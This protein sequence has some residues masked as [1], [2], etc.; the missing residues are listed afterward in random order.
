MSIPDKARDVQIDGCL[1]RLLGDHADCYLTDAVGNKVPGSVLGFAEAVP[2]T[3][4]SA[5]LDLL[6]D[7]L[8]DHG[9]AIGDGPSGPRIV[10][11]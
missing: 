3:A 6:V 8:R 5:L 7:E 2:I 4:Y 10:K 9:L 1:F 11:K